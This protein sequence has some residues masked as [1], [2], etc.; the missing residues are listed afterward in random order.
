M[1][2]IEYGII[3]YFDILCRIVITPFEEPT[4]MFIWTSSL[5]KMGRACYFLSGEIT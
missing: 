3:I 1:I 2:L 5:P 4:R